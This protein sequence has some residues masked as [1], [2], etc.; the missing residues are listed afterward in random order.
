MTAVGKRQ[1]SLT[2]AKGTTEL[3]ALAQQANEYHVKAKD[4]AETFIQAARCAG[5]ALL[6]AKKIIGHGGWLA[7]LRNNFNASAATAE[8]YMNVA[9]KWKKFLKNNG[10]D[11]PQS[12][13]QFL[14]LCDGRYD[15]QD[16]TLPGETKQ[17]KQKHGPAKSLSAE[18]AAMS[19]TVIV[20]EFRAEMNRLLTDEEVIYLKTQTNR[21]Q[22]EHDITRF[23]QALKKDIKPFV[24]PYLTAVKNLELS[25]LDAE[26]KPPDATDE[27]KKAIEKMQQNLGGK[28]LSRYQR[29]K[30]DELQSLVTE[31][32][33]SLD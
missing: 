24:G 16:D 7:W 18:Y 10:G 21:T 20:Q 17:L 12:I 31:G 28:N 13:R 23:V 11:E 6:K 30:I 8:V 19:R 15:Q 32:V 25:R 26:A 5:Q 33:T 9:R 22:V 3:E 1:T 4:A 14:D 27:L 2:I 29:N